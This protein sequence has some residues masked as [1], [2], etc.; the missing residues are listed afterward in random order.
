MQGQA[1]KLRKIHAFEFDSARKRMSIIL[2]DEA[3]GV[4]K[5]YVKGADNIIKQRLSKNTPQP[6]LD[7]TDKLLEKFS[8][9]GLRTLM[10]AMKVL[11]E[12]EVKAFTQEY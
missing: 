10:M 12:E 6:F 5:M 4:Y 9:I 11:T 7:N 1:I 3:A 2:K 8:I